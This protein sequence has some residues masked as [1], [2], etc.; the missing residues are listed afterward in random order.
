MAD[1]YERLVTTLRSLGHPVR[2]Q[3][4]YGITER[5]PE[6]HITYQ[7]T[8]CDPKTHADNSPT[9]YI[10]TF[11]VSMYSMNPETVQAA[12]RLLRT[13]LLAAGFFGGPGRRLPMDVQTGQYGYTADFKLHES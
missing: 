4:T 6:T 10:T 9:S 5:L 8:L 2:E 12:D 3:G 11:Q 13:V 1:A 7:M